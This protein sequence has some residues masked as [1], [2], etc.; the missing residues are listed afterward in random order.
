[1]RIHTGIIQV[2]WAL[3]FLKCMQVDYSYPESI[4]KIVGVLEK[5]LMDLY[6]KYGEKLNETLDE[7]TEEIMPKSQ[8]FNSIYEK[9][10]K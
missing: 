8:Y 10:K 2:E 6:I 9:K 3:E 5:N 7:S 1:M 4:R